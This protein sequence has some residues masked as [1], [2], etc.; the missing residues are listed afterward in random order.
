MKKPCIYN[1]FKTY[2]LYKYL[3]QFKS[4]SFLSFSNGRSTS[5]T[6]IKCRCWWPRRPRSARASSA[7]WRGEACPHRSTY[8][9]RRRR[10]IC[11]SNEAAHRRRRRLTRKKKWNYFLPPSSLYY[12]RRIHNKS[13]LFI[14]YLL[15][16]FLPIETQSGSTTR[17]IIYSYI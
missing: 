12:T 17:V 7:F 15:T 4:V 11:T 14:L 13:S 2:I 6:R 16:H 9:R 8:T 10:Y 1:I 5:L 3:H